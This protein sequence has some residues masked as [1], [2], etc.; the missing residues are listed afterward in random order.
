MT[1]A[2]RAW[3]T[4][5]CVAACQTAL[6]EGSRLTREGDVIE[7]GDCEAEL[8][9][10][11]MRFR[12]QPVERQS[13]M[14]LA[15]GIGWQTELEATYS[16]HRVDAQSDE[17]MALEAKTLLRER[18]RGGI[19]WTLALGVGGERDSGG[20]WRR[21]GQSIAVEASIVP[22]ED[23][24]FEVKFGAARERGPRIDKTLWSLAVER[25]IS[26]TLEMRAELDGDDRTRPLA[27]IGLRWAFWPDHAQLKLSYGAKSGPQRERRTGLAVKYEF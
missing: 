1:C 14:R 20:A 22:A 7:Q 8:A 3:A 21:S 2:R 18:E 9:R 13:S 15:C 19:G 25:A 12:G 4:L 6:A 11:R 17:S 10:E 16:R 26:D 5:A 23:W 27:A 24:L